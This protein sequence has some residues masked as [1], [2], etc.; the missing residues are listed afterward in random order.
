MPFNRKHKRSMKGSKLNKRQ[1]K[2]VEKIVHKNIETKYVVDVTGVSR[3]ITSV[4][5]LQP[6][7][8]AGVTGLSF[9]HVGQLTTEG[10]RIGDQIDIVSFKIRYSV[11]LNNTLLFTADPWAYARVILFRWKGESFHDPPSI[12]EILTLYPISSAGTPSLQNVLAPHNSER[13]KQYQ[14]LYDKTHYLSNVAVYNGSTVSSGLDPG[15]R[16]T[17]SVVLRGKKLGSR[18]IYFTQS[19]DNALVTT[20]DGINHLYMFTISNSASGSHPQI[21][22]V[23]ELGFKDA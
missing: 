22:W 3:D 7:T 11:E 13:H 17:R 23:T 15:S 21:T 8:A 10:G 4:G 16:L 6:A 9:T 1:K 18:R 20:N 14:I 2:E 19:N 5:Q 12:G